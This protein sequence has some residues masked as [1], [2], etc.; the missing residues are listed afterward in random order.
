MPDP[1]PV[2]LTL[3]WPQRTDPATVASVAA[4]V[5]KHVE[6]ALVA[7]AS[8]AKTAR[9]AGWQEGRAGGW[10]EGYEAGRQAGHEAGR[11]EGESHAWKLTGTVAE[12]AAAQDARDRQRGADGK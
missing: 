10:R 5:A 11:R 9:A 8:T 1:K 6:N 4:Q 3:E 12:L 7:G 2:N